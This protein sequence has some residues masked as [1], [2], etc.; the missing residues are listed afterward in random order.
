MTTANLTHRAGIYGR[1]PKVIFE[2]IKLHG[3][4]ETHT[5]DALNYIYFHRYRYDLGTITPPPVRAVI[6]CQPGANSGASGWYNWAAQMAQEGA[7]ELEI[8]VINRREH[9]IQETGPLLEAE[10]T[11][12]F[13]HALDYY[14]GKDGFP[15]TKSEGVPFMAHW[16]LDTYAHDVRAILSLIP[17]ERQRTNVFLAGQSQGGMFT[18]T[19]AGY[20]FPD[21]SA[22]FEHLA[23]LIV[24]DGGPRVAPDNETDA[25]ARE[26]RNKVDEL[27]TGRAPRF[28]AVTLG[29]EAGPVA[30]A[31]RALQCMLGYFDPAG[32]SPFK[33]DEPSLGGPEA[34]DFKKRLRLTN[35]A[36]VG[37]LFDDDPIP[38]AALQTQAF[39]KMGS[40][41]GRLDFP[42]LKQ[43]GLPWSELS[44]N[45]LYTWLSGG[46]GE[47]GGESDDG[48][49]NGYPLQNWVPTPP[50]PSPTRVADA[51]LV[52]FFNS[53]TGDLWYSSNRYHAD[54]ARARTFD[55]PEVHVTARSRIDIPLIVY[56]RGGVTL[57]GAAGAPDVEGFARRTKIG[58]WTFVDE[59]G[60][61][62]S[63]P[64]RL[65]TELPEGTNTR[66]YN[67]SDFLRAE[68]SRAGK[69]APGMVGANVVTNTALQ[70][71]LARATG[72]TPVPPPEKLER[73]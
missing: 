24:I 6:L 50:N 72:T 55:A 43:P 71:L 20:Q 46:S 33:P 17:Q 52:R 68:N 58:D 10:G 25:A 69:V 15:N 41:C 49:L 5:P 64:A 40:R 2:P 70:W 7:G 65:R 63:A 32:E 21:G 56:A 37:F 38:G 34:D 48:P 16:G 3:H 39:Y 31:R 1:Y 53:S 4:P 51:A 19:F 60:V 8:W 11:Q 18:T 67:H 61:H 26:W 14:S 28:G 12:D 42:A 35:R 73:E 9:G 23:G 45:K 29:R 44:P 54:L 13:Q 27:I 57:A 66:L 59:R 47:P 30:G 62:S 36:F 22:G